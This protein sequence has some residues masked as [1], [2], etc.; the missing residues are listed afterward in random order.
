LGTLILLPFYIIE[1]Q[2]QGGFEFNLQNIS[3]ILFLG[4]GASVICFLIWN[5]SIHILAQ[6]APHCLA[7]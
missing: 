3:A 1:W 4:L 6:A 5:K 7:I 2:H